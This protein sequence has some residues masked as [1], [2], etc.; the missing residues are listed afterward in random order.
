M[1]TKNK[2]ATLV[3][4]KVIFDGKG[5]LVTERTSSNIDSI[6]HLFYKE[7]FLFVKKYY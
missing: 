7:R 4:Y 1:T 3:G 6:K 2:E 5:N